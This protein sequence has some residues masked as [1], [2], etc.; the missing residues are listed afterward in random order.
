[1]T[2][3]PRIHSYGNYSS[4]NY[5][6]NT[7]VVALPTITLCYSYRT[8]VAFYYKGEEVVSQNCWGTTTGKHL[9]WINPNHKKRIPYDEFLV[10]LNKALEEIFGNNH[11]RIYE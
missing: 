5:G 8:I 2:E 4:G 1:M 7:L 9:N 6:V 3:L 10:K 11:E